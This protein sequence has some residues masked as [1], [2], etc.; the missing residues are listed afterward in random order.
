M[1][2]LLFIVTIVLAI[3]GIVSI[4]NKAKERNV[5]FI[6][7]ASKETKK[8]VDKIKGDAKRGWESDTLV[9]DSIK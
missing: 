3:I 4:S 5:T 7:Q 6:E 9:I 2:R 8:G 1:R